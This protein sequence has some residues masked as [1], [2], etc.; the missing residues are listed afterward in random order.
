MDVAE[1]FSYYF[2]DLTNKFDFLPHLL[3]LNYLD[4]L[5]TSS[6]SFL[7]STGNTP[8][9]TFQ[10]IA[11]EEVERAFLDL[12]ASSAAGVSNIDSC[13]LVA[14]I[15][16]LKIPITD[17]FNLCLTTG[18]IPNE[19]K[20]AYVTPIYKGSGSM[21]DL[22]NYRPISILPPIAKIFERLMSVRIREFF[23]SNKLLTSNQYSFREGLSCE[24][25]LN[26]MIDGWKQSLDNRKFVIS[27]FLDLSK[28][29]DTIDHSLLLQKL[30]Y[31]RFNNQALL[32]IKNYLSNRYI[33]TK[34]NG[35]FSNP[36]EVKV[37]VPQ[38][39]VLGPLLFIIFMND[40]CHLPIKTD[41]NLFADDLTVTSV[42]STVS[43][44]L[45]QLTE[46]LKIV[47]EWIKH[48]RLVINWKKTHAMLFN[49]NTTHHKFDYRN[50]DLFFDGIK[51]EFLEHTRI[52]GVIIDHNLD[53]N[54]HIKQTCNKVNG[55]TRQLQ[56]SAF[57]FGCNFKTTLFKSFILSKFDYCS[58]V[59][60]NNIFFYTDSKLVRCF[61]S[62]L[63]RL[64]NIEIS[65]VTP[66]FQL[67]MLKKIHLL[68]LKLRLIVRFAT[69]VHNLIMR[70]GSTILAK[71]ILD[72]KQHG[73]LRSSF[74]LPQF[75]T[76]HSQYSFTTVAIKFLNSP[77]LKLNITIPKSQFL[78]CICEKDILFFESLMK[79][80]N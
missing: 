55:K 76:H 57:M 33:I 49:F 66:S 48:N 19:W 8:L 53:F 2:S 64:L 52:L 77:I 39:S 80:W 6:I 75:N 74:T 12:D 73:Q 7:N 46:D 78:K 28:A 23:E 62:S 14:C 37:G 69:F 72:H 5:F 65:F 60:I 9:F 30:K 68:P 67:S 50:C 58:T 56:K 71:R 79:I 22:N 32:L 63:K 18:E 36:I 41:I 3:C 13:I 16:E 26:T 38:G 21:A 45:E 54:E 25:S 15:D 44:A 43:I 47:S 51:I 35:S 34:I 24:L 59:F 4:K 40:I 1:L 27:L 20:V 29:F 42:G 70:N 17:L 61:N 11:V 10:P 31:Y